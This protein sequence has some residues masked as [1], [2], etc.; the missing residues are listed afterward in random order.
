MNQN[1]QAEQQ[2]GEGTAG[3]GPKYEVNI[4]GTIH[5]WDSDVITTEQ[6]IELGGWEASQGVIEIDEDN[7]EH[8]L[9][10]GEVIHLKPGHG[11]ARKVRFKRG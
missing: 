5:P 11:F 10:S 2:K 8:T 6:L 7:N 4:E 3:K 1:E 9:Q